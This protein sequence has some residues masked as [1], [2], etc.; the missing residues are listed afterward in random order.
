MKCIGEGKR[1]V[2]SAYRYY[3]SLRECMKYAM[4]DMQMGL[5]KITSGY[6]KRQIVRE[7]P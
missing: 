4:Y 1:D 2:K 7:I 5:A 6:I 3:I